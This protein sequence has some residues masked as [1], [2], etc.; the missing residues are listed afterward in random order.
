MRE[1]DYIIIGSGLN[2]L[3][4]A[5][6]L[7][8]RGHNVCV[9]ERNHYLGGCIR[10]DRDSLPGYTFDLMSISHVQFITSPAYAELKADLQ[11]AGLEYCVNEHPTGVM[12][13][14]GRSLIL[15]TDHAENVDRITALS[16]R[17]GAAYD[18]LIKAFQE[19]A[20]VVFSL[21]G[22]E[23]WSWGTVKM[24]FSE[25]RKRGLLGLTSLFGK[26]MYSTRQLLDQGFESDEGRALLA[27]GSLHAGLGPDATMSAL[28]GQ[29][30][31]LSLAQASDPMVKGGSD[32]LVQAFK[33]LI[34][35]HGGLLLTSQDVESVLT[36][37]SSA[38]GVQTADKTAYRAERG[39]IGNVT[40]TQLYQ[41]LLKPSDLPSNI[42]E[43]TQQFRYGRSCMIVHIAMDE[44][45]QWLDAE[46]SKVALMHLTSGLDGVTKAVSEADRGLL[47]ES[48]TICVVQP[49]AVDPSRAPEGKW[50]LWLQLLELPKVI[51]GDAKR[52]I[53]IP[54]DGTWNEP[55]KEAFADRLLDNLAKVIPNLKNSLIYRNVLSPADLESMNINLVGGDPY[56]GHCG[57]DQQL[58]FRPLPSL[59][60]HSTPFKKLYHIGAS[61]HPGPGLGG[62]SGFMVAKALN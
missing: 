28:M 20:N 10:T 34:E 39:V 26:L 22:G 16:E 2:S 25:A 18:G 21:L 11:E 6:L 46:M 37:G 19:N 7:A 29:L 40:P 8:K 49:L 42:V 54:A 51:K 48:P 1:F 59:K 50:I 53:S 43:Q 24:L 27:P 41:R 36:E 31:T 62:M 33:T 55:V 13:P 15:T 38:I 47:P 30:V 52:E 12:L 4:C 23:P 3:V 32:K 45:P 35:K 9:L 5:A 60:N 17:D 56:S 61:T 44:K 58:L 14:D 57:V